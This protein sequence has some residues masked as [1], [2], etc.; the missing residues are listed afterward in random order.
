MSTLPA[1]QEQQGLSRLDPQAL[2]AKAIEAG[3]SVEAI[4]KLVDLAIR[5]RDVQAKEA[6]SA[7]LAAF[8][9]ACP[10]IVKRERARIRTKTG[11]GFEYTYASLDG[12]LDVA[13]PV[14]N[15]HGLSIAWRTRTD[16]KAAYARCVLRHALG[17]AEE[18][19]EIR[20]PIEQQG[21]GGTGASPAQRVGIALTYAKR[22]A[23]LAALGLAPEKGEDT[24]GKAPE[25]H[26][27]PATQDDE[28][29]QV[30]TI[31][32]NQIHMLWAVAAK[33]GWGDKQATETAVHD[34]L[35]AREIAH[36]KDV[37]AA[38]FNALL[39][40]LKAGPQPKR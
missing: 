3:T 23:A 22:Y 28:P 20:I 8:Q 39:T 27:E 29:G 37:P 38:R 36:V 5:M 25:G 30:T 31:S 16:E 2:L 15:T 13:Q 21:E 14:A 19:D 40:L 10:P 33:S 26:E 18:G 4:E 24:D 17:H 32:E 1:V 12:V 7:A 9:S 11:P 34:I 35:S 6:Y